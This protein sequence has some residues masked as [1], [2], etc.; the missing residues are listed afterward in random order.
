MQMPLWAIGA[1]MAAGTAVSAISSVAQG[2][3][4]AN[5]DKYN[6]SVAT[7]DQNIANQ[8]AANAT[9]IAATQESDVKYKAGLQ[10]GAEKAAAGASGADPNSGSP[11][12]LMT[13]TARQTTLDALRTRYQGQL[14]SINDQNQALGYGYQAQLDNYD[15]SQAQA[16]GLLKAGASILNGATSY[17]MW[18][19]RYSAGGGEGGSY[20]V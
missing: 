6:A 8:N 20:M 2:N 14:T 4:Q 16:G 10:L 12:A 5:A 18:Q 13:D 1:T 3:A 9:A 15:A 7:L 19:A 11:L 17:G